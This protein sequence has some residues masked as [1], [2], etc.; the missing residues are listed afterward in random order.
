MNYRHIIDNVMG[1]RVTFDYWL[2]EVSELLAEVRAL[3]WRGIREEWSDVACLGTLHLFSRGYTW[4]A[5]LPVLPGLGLY[6][7]RKFEA[8]N[9]TWERIFAHHGVAFER[10]YIIRG[11]NFAKLQKVSM[12]LQQ[13][14]VFHLDKAWLKA[15]GIC[16]A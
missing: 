6:A 15:E 3:N 2:G 14:G 4:I 8:R 1:G 16:V 11:G 12:A 9:A 5:D 13:A 7:A 10:R